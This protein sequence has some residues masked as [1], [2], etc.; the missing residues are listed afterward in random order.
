MERNDTN[1]RYLAYCAA[2]GETD[3]EAMLAR[4]RERY[5]GGCMVGFIQW[6]TAQW[7]EWLTEQAKTH[8]ELA[9]YN[10]HEGEMFRL[11]HAANY[12]TWL[13]ARAAETL[14]VHRAALGVERAS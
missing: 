6:N 9:G 11:T 5:P 10:A 12:D 1:P 4:D 3:P 13:Q 8:P 14:R 7:R 2:H